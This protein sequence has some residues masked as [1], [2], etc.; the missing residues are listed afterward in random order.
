MTLISTPATNYD[1]APQMS[2]ILPEQASMSITHLS[3][4]A[5]RATVALL[6]L[7]LSLGD[8]SRVTAQSPNRTRPH[9]PSSLANTAW[10]GFFLGTDTTY[11]VLL[12]HQNGGSAL[13][14][15]QAHV[16]VDGDPVVDFSTGRGEKGL[17]WVQ[18]NNQLCLGADTVKTV[19]EA[20]L[21]SP[22]LR[23]GKW[24]HWNKVKYIRGSFPSSGGS[25]SRKRYP[26]P[27][28]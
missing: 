25:V 9:R 17:W 8:T 12:L 3:P 19:R 20:L 10:A 13:Y 14:R 21:C 6:A 16:D 18:D 27:A 5:Q 26:I 2:R 28:P 15:Y 4:L 1:A 22:A 24:L 7:L 23:Q 11:Y